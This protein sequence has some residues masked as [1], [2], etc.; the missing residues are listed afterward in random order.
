M[1]STKSDRKRR[2]Q[3]QRTPDATQE[4]LDHEAEIKLVEA[5]ASALDIEINATVQ[6]IIHTDPHDRSQAD[7][8][9][10]AVSPEVRAGVIKLFRETETFQ[11]LFPEYA[12]LFELV[13]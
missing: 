12:A 5:G 8:I 13:N 4:A 6:K 7:A 2:L 10:S 9:L 11:E 3:K 1:M